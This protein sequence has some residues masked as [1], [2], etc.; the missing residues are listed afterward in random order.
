MDEAVSILDV[1]PDP[2]LLVSNGRIE[3]ANEAAARLL[4]RGAGELRGITFVELFEPRSAERL[5]HVLESAP[6]LSPSE[7]KV[8]LLGP[9]GRSERMAHL[10]RLGDGRF[11]VSL[12]TFGPTSRLD[13]LVLELSRVGL[14][15]GGDALHDIE[16]LLSAAR[17]IFESLGWLLVIFEVQDKGVLVREVFWPRRMKARVEGELPGRRLIGRSLPF[18][19]L[20]GVWPT[21]RSGKVAMVGEEDSATEARRFLSSIDLEEQDRARY[22]ALIQGQKWLRGAWAPAVVE[23]RTAYLVAAIDSELSP[24]DLAAVRLFADQIAGTV[25]MNR[26]QQAMVEKQRGAALGQMSTL[27]AHEV[28]NPLAILFQAARQIRRRVGEKVSV[29]DL[30]DILEE[31]AERLNRLVDDLVSFAGP[32]RPRLEAVALSTLV[33]LVVE[34]LAYDPAK[35]ALTVNVSDELPALLAD[36]L[37]LRKAIAHLLGNAISHVER[38]GRVT[39]TAE[40]EG[41]LWVVLRVADDGEAIPEDVRGRIFEPFFTTKARGSGLGLAVVRRIVEELGGAVEVEP[42]ERGK[43][44]RLRMPAFLVASVPTGGGA[45]GAGVG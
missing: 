33:Q 35:V 45:S 37:L 12:R 1:L 25:T 27:L 26:L 10:G 28:R 32:I 38:G 18:E 23:G 11:V 8:H 17:P 7:I 20:G 42:R 13:E 16:T 6:E 5:G 44:F 43:S 15:G 36:P 39:V 41:P 4:G 14:E 40:A 19:A 30:L 3:R 22:A 24:S 31:E 9:A 21:L 2:T 29:G 34:G